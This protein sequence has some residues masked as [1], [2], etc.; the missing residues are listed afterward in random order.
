VALLEAGIEPVAVAG[1][2]LG[3]LA[4]L[5][6]AG[7]YS[8]EAGLELV[9]ERSR[10]MAVAA[11]SSPGGMLA[12]IGL[13]AAQIGEAIQD[14]DQVWIANDNSAKQVVVS[15]AADAIGRAEESLTAAGAR[16]VIPLK[17][18]GAFHTPL[19]DSAQSSFADILGHT[20]F[21]DATIPVIQNTD[22]TPATDGDEIRR[23]LSTQIASPV[24]WTE[25]MAA[26]R[27]GETTALVEAGPGSVL[28][29]LAR[30]IDEVKGFAAE[31]I[32]TERIAE[33]VCS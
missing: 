26:L 14:I 13:P 33:E 28:T 22:P 3:E 32:G 16:R 2:S 10:L 21:F 8:P 11:A 29:G 25:S 20:E 30:G 15:G 7:V 18:A 9:V 31:E 4:A 24:R 27:A 23:R 6:I 12:V 1:H 19:M 17:V 5:A